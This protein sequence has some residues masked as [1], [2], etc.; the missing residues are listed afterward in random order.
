M[1][2]QAMQPRVSNASLPRAASPGFCCGK[3]AF[4]AGLPEETPKS[5]ESR[6]RPAGTTAFSSLHAIGED[7]SAI[8]E[9]ILFSV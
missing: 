2:W 5:R 8:P 9:S 7:P 4:T 1:E 3:S 6:H